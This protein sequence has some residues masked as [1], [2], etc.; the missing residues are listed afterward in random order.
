MKSNVVSF[1]IGELP[2][3][4]QLK[5][6]TPSENKHQTDTGIDHGETSSSE[7]LRNLD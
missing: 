2:G 7:M 5:A 6:H 3:F 4:S 1:L